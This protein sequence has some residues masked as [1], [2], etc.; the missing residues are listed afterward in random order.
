MVV[1][2]KM[3]MFKFGHALYD[4]DRVVRQTGEVVN[5]GFEEIYVSACVRDGSAVSELME[6]F[7]NDSSYN[8]SKYPVT[9]NIKKRY[10]ETEEGES[11]M[12]EIMERLNEDTK[13]EVTAR[14]N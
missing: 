2:F 7:T 6:I 13:K 3:Y 1:I 5:N 9:S 14:L 8:M 4:I 12:C 10:K 11:I